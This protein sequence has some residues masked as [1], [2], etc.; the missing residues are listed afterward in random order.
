M[1]GDGRAIIYLRD[2]DDIMDRLTACWAYKDRRGLHVVRIVKDP[3]GSEWPAVH[4]LGVELHAEALIIYDRAE[5]PADRL[6]RL[7]VVTE[8]TAGGGADLAGRRGIIYVRDGPLMAR[9]CE[10]CF[11]YA[12]ERR[13]EVIRVVKDPDGRHWPDIHDTAVHGGTDVVILYDRAE[14]PPDRVPRIEVVTD[15]QSAGGRTRRRRPWTRRK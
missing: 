4:Q 14:L 3:D 1:T 10:R 15:R 13:I 8:Q 11:G 5:L 7:V 2:G 6:P 9:H 12:A